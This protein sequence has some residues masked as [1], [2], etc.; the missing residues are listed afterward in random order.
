[1]DEKVELLISKFKNDTIMLDA[2][3]QW[4]TS[5]TSST[6]V[7]KGCPPDHRLIKG[8]ITKRYALDDEKASEVYNNLVEEIGNAG[9][10]F[11]RGYIDCKE[12][13]KERV[14]DVLRKETLERLKTASQKEKHIVW[15]YCKVE[16]NFDLNP[17]KYIGWESV[18]KF[19]TL[20]KVV[21]NDSPEAHKE[22]FSDILI[23][24]GLINRLVWNKSKCKNSEV[25][26]VFPHY[27][28][29]L[30]SEIDQYIIFPELPDYKKYIDALFDR[31]VI[32][33]L[34]F[35]D[36][37]LTNNERSDIGKCVGNISHLHGEIIPHPDIIAKGSDF[38][39]IN[40]RIYESFKDY[41]FERKAKELKIEKEIEDTLTQ[42]YDNHYP[43]LSKE[44]KE[45]PELFKTSKLWLIDSYDK[46]LAESEVLIILTP[47]LT[48]KEL[49][50]LRTHYSQKVVVI[51]STLMGIPDFNKLYKEIISTPLLNE[52]K[53]N[54]MILDFSKEK[55]YELIVNDKP[56][57]F[58]ELKGILAEKLKLSPEP[59]ST[60]EPEEELIESTQL[61]IEKEKTKR[62][63][64]DVDAW[65]KDNVTPDQVEVLSSPDVP[66]S[67]AIPYKITF[68][69]Y[70]NG[71]TL[72]F[73]RGPLENK[74]AWGFDASKDLSVET[75]VTSDL[76][77][78]NQ[79]HVG[80]FQQTRTGKSTLASCVILQVAFQGIPV[81]VVDPKPD[82]VSGLIPIL[83]TI[84]RHPSYKAT[85]EK[86][87]E[88]A[89]QDIR[90]F[91][92][93]RDVEFEQDGKQRKIHFQIYSFR[94]DLQGLPNC[95]VLKLPL[96]VLP[97]LEDPDFFKDQCN[98]AATSL[99]SCLSTPKGKA[100]N[101]LLSEIMKK[102]KKENPE[103]EFMV[104]KDV[105]Q[106]LDLLF[107]EAD[108]EDKKRIK[109]LC[110]ALS[111]YCTKNSYLYAENEEEVV[112]ID[113]VI[114]NPEYNDGDKQTVSIA[115]IDVSTL[116]Q[117]KGN[118]VMQNYV[119]QLCGQLYSF[120]Q[121][122]RSDRPVQLFMV[123]DEAQN[124]LP[125]P[126]D[127]YNYARVIINRGASLG[128]KAWLMA[129]SPQAVEK[130]ARK[131]FTAL[132]LSQVNEA[133]VRDEVSKYVQSNSW[134]DKL[135]RTELGKALIINSETGEEGGKICVVF[136]TPQT[137]NILSSKQIAKVMEQKGV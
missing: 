114:S 53:L 81:V 83:R 122:R 84:S 26:N 31:R 60:P 133:S 66:L 4:A 29:P 125:D 32:K 17:C 67:S 79:P 42:L 40:P 123:F 18:N 23:R 6:A 71:K 37:L 12:Q 92:F 107:K 72:V 50:H 87:F 51:I 91:D 21:F 137:V 24:I 98:A 62:D 74:I 93:S 117:E 102:F 16:D 56:L 33:P 39:A 128:I 101:T 8:N 2:L 35:L 127:Q 120:V 119:S 59:K 135:K 112:R 64:K 3:Y 20:L 27:L 76:H 73:G 7:S 94:K 89:R 22:G 58:D 34:V 55:L 99:V 108:K 54:W 75:L 11:V 1:M 41:F 65:D 113:S 28:K 90:G 111:D 49:E 10:D 126:S 78:I 44:T 61:Q 15:L 88:E 85:I 77:D 38:V 48:G 96:L 52:S 103:R 14:G 121:R 69:P 132:V 105:E 109:V 47:Y 106:E 9:I 13:I 97:S 134:T 115:I 131:Q 63:E 19:N 130:E 25:S 80:S 36:E 110:D 68:P 104:K 124:Y 82:Y 116:P 70:D 57:L 100:F 5:P 45:K 136:T 86:R 30:L 95:R 46:S 129:Q 118:P 43:M